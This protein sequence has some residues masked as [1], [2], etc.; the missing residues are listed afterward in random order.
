M[1]LN[2]LQ[3]QLADSSNNKDKWDP[4][5]CGEI[6]LVIK[7]DGSW[8]YVGSPIGRMSLVKLFASVLRKENEQYMLV[9]PV[10]KVIIRVEDVPFVVTQWNNLQ[11]VLYFT[12]SLGDEVPV[13]Q[14][15][16]VELKRHN[17]TGEIIPYCLIRDE[18][19]ARLH[20]NVFYQLAAAGSIGHWQGCDHLL[21]R[22]GEY[23]FTLGEV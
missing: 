9:T 4:P 12:T 7:Q 14:Q 21:I 6:D 18:L 1:E 23:Q 13:N 2:N 3:A 5:L 10:E 20:Q 8:H 17:L 22:S 11:G 16:P 19:W 15:H